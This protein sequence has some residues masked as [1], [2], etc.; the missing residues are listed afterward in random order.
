M[1]RV[2]HLPRVV[3]LSAASRMSV[4]V[5]PYKGGHDSLSGRSPK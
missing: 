4:F 2:D 3:L 5:N 1:R